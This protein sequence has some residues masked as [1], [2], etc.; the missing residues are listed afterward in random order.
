[1]NS[2]NFAA[3]DFRTESKELGKT[4]TITVVPMWR[5]AKNIAAR[6]CRRSNAKPTAMASAADIRLALTT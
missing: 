2:I 3:R 6:I 4:S 5:T 1:M